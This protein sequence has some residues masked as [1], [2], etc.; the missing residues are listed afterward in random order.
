MPGA[1]WF[2]LALMGVAA[3]QPAGPSTRP[4]QPPTQ[5]ESRPAPSTHPVATGGADSRPTAVAD[6]GD[7]ADL[8]R[9]LADPDWHVRRKAVDQ[10]VR[11]G[12]DAK[13]FVRT[14]IDKATT[15]EARKNAQAALAEIDDNR[16]TGPSYL[17]LHLKN[18]T[19]SEVFAEISR[20]CGAPILTAPDNLFQAEPFPKV[21]VDVDRQ[22][23]WEV[24]PRICR[25]LGVDFRH[26]QGGMR[27]MRDGG[28]VVGGATHVDGPFLVMATQISY[29]R[30][31]SFAGRGEQTQ[32]G[33]HVAVYPEPKLNV[34]RGSGTIQ[35]DQAIDDHGNSLAPEQNPMRNMWGVFM[36][37]GGV[38]LVA[39][40]HYPKNIGARMTHFK[41]STTFVIQVESQTL[42][43]RDL[44]NFRPVT[45][46]IFDMPVAFQQFKRNGDAWQLHLHI[47]QPNYASADWQ[48]F[49]DGVQNRL[50]ILDAQG[51]PFDHRGMSTGSSNGT[52]DMTLDYA[53][54]TTPT[55]QLCGEPARLL[56]EVPTKTRQITVPIEFKD[57]PLFDDK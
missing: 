27:L 35:I 10:L 17:T 12:T 54:S 42:D 25:Q 18:A 8:L 45:R 15:E 13:P 41:G 33:M 50:Q 32:F 53:R 23:F 51:T 44:A 24:V 40:L 21:T 22:A 49:M 5:P 14:L 4:A 3:S 47:D 28:M 52:M 26:Y 38:N 20:Q 7:P 2:I 36:G 34:L 57:L 9:R 30:T 31:R 56:W 39:P 37:Y 55:G 6:F 29:S 11:G 46:T 19:A 1:G 43:M 16:L 48:Q